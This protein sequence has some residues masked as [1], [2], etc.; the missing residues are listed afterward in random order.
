M[1]KLIKNTIAILSAGVISSSLIMG[2]SAS[3]NTNDY[4]WG[5]SPNGNYYASFTR[6]TARK[7]TDSSVVVKNTARY[8]SW[9]S[10]VSAFGNNTTN[11]LN[12]EWADTYSNWGA[13]DTF[14]VW[15]PGNSCRLIRQY[16]NE[17]GFPYATMIFDNCGI[18]TS[19]GTWSPDATYYESTHYGTAN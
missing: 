11:S 19:Q 2:L 15:V 14:R 17:N 13:L 5:C 4:S 18:A 12:F 8:S 1:S 9:G 10:Y 16:I 7:D 3:A 6:S